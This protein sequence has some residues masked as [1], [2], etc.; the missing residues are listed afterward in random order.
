[1]DT[2][3]HGWKTFYANYRELLGISDNSRN[4]C[5]V[6]SA[7]VFIGVCPWLISSNKNAPDLRSEAWRSSLLRRT[8]KSSLSWCCSVHRSRC[9]AREGGRAWQIDSEERLAALCGCS[10]LPNKLPQAAK[11]RKVRSKRPQAKRP[12]RFARLAVVGEGDG[13]ERHITDVI[14]EFPVAQV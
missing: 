3:S 4:S 5:Q 2:D 14:Q 6:F 1:M 10:M 8:L 9:Q 11:S 13:H 12:H 7:S